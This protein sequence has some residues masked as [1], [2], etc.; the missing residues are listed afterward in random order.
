[1]LFHLE[2]E[3]CI[4]LCVE[5]GWGFKTVTKQS[6]L[7][8][9]LSWIIEKVEER[10]VNCLGFEILQPELESG[11]LHLL[12]LNDFFP[13]YRSSMRAGFLQSKSWETLGDGSCIFLHRNLQSDVPTSTSAILLLVTQTNLSTVHTGRLHKSMSTSR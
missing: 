10:V 6:E 12:A 3:K 1:M 2:N 7:Y 4:D 8:F 5:V 11:F 13:I 9:G